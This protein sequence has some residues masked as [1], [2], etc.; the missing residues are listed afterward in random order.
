MIRDQ[1]ISQIS[2]RLG[3]NS[4][5]DPQSAL[6]VVDPSTQTLEL[7]VADSDSSQQYAVSTASNGLGNQIDS[8]QTPTG[9]H[10][11]AEK[12]GANEPNG[13]VFRG[14]KAT[15]VI[16]ADMDNQQEDQ[17]T[18]RILW[19]RGMEPGFNQ[20][21]ER[22]SFDRYIY[23]HGTSDEQRIGKPVSAG[24]VRMRNDDVIELFDRVEVG[25]VVLILDA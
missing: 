15:G 23:I 9:V 5:I 17:I 7:F 1:V 10:I 6:L 21:G 13:M 2:D 19:L 25:D 8:F 22:D 18:S 4:I 3:D 24:C 11:V 14:R 16:T 12:I 20:G